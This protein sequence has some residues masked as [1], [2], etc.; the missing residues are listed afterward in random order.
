MTGRPWQG[1][2]RFVP[3]VPSVVDKGVRIIDV[4]DLVDVVVDVDVDLRG[5][6]VGGRHAQA[7]P[8]VVVGIG[9]LELPRV[10]NV[11]DV[12]QPETG[13]VGIVDPRSVGVIQARPH[14]VH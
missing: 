7:V 1:S 12:G 14:R 10:R 6:A 4:G 13:V 2:A 5:A 3:T 8:H 11:V 9:V